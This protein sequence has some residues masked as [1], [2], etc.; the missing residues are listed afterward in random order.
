M[1][2]FKEK[3][4]KFPN[5]FMGVSAVFFV[6]IM[7]SILHK[8]IKNKRATVNS[9]N[10]DEKFFKFYA[11]IGALNYE[12]I[13]KDPERITKIKSFINQHKWKNIIFLQK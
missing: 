8:C 6:I 12:N 9:K 1:V 2:R 7:K 10:S 5:T 13:G 4:I 3:F 11:I